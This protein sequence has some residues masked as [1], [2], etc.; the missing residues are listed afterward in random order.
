MM[1]QRLSLQNIIGMGFMAFAMFLGAGNLIFPPLVG[2][3][4]GTATWMAAAGFLITGVGLPLLGLIVIARVGGGFNEITREL[5]RGI[6]ILIGSCIYLII[7]PIYAVPRTGM[8]AYEV[9]MIPF[10]ESPDATSRFIYSLVFFGIAWYLSLYPGKLLETVGKIITPALVL[11]LIVLGISPIL[12]P[13]GE[14]GAA[15]GGY[16]DNAFIRGFLEGYMT[17]DALAALMFG[18]VIITNL[19]SHGITSTRALFRHS[20]ITGVIAATGLALVYMSLF[21]LGA[22]SRD[23]IPNPENGGQIL[24]IYVEMLFGL[25]GSILLAMVVSLACLTTAIGCITAASEYFSQLTNKIRYTWI[26]AIISILCMMFANLGLNQIIK[27]FIPVLLILYP[28]CIALILLGLVRDFI[29]APTLVYRSTLLVAFIL[30]LVDAAKSFNLPFLHTIV[31]PFSVIPGYD[32]NLSWLVP[33]LSC[34]I[35]TAL[36]GK[37]FCPTSLQ[38]DQA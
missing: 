20:V 37:I 1:N 30:S 18:I 11:L 27:L 16:A 38:E 23:V 26:V 33:S 24:A 15:T 3:L 21:H 32:V 22:T 8:V 10:L 4:A 19:R 2:Q 12:M 7:G 25:A 29:P 13:L 36:F 14:P 28:V 9:G 31:E 17:M 34:A 5:P 6:I 35:L